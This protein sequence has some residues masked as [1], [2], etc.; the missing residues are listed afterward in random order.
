[1]VRWGR[2]WNPGADSATSIRFSKDVHVEDQP[3]AAGEY[4]LWVIPE[5]AEPWTMIFSRATHVFH[6]PY[7]GEAR[8]ALRLSVRPEQGAHM[9]VLAFYFPVVAPDSATLRL[10]WG[11]TIVPLRIRVDN[12]R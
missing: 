10:H 3:L 4:T 8:D 5:E 12:R 2:V 11:T 6:T 1:V 9:E 7:P